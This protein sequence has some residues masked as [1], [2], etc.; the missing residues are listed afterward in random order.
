LNLLLLLFN[1]AQTVTEGQSYLLL[2]KHK[3]RDCILSLHR[4]MP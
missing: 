3:H 2:Y 1:D 4:F